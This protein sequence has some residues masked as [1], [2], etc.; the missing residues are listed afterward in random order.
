MSD[1]GKYF[2]IVDGGA[3]TGLKGGKTSRFLEHSLRRVTV[4][5]YED[6]MVTENL[7]IG[8]S[9]TKITDVNGKQLILIENEQIDHTGQDNSIMSV[10][11]VRAFGVDVDDC[12]AIYSRNGVQG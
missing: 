7:P 12:P 8:T 9:A 1:S 3:D 5:G 4:S 6:D 10:N 2:V 11:Q